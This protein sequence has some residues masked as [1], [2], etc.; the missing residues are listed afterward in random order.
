MAKGRCPRCE[1]PI[2]EIT[3]RV[4]G[5][6]VVMQSCSAC[7]GRWWFTDGKPMPL[8][9]VLERINTGMGRRAPQTTA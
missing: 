9:G 4:D 6:D 7:E 5:E 8:G 3:I 1:K 2:V